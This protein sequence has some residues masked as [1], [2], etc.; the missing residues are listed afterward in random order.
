MSLLAKAVAIASTLLALVQGSKISLASRQTLNTTCAD[1]HYFEARGTTLPYPGSLIT[2]IDPLMKAFPNSNYE[3]IVYPATDESGSD[4]YFVGVR[5]GAK[6]IISY[7]EACPE[8]KIV[9]M[10]YSQG[11][12]VLGDILAGGGDGNVLGNY[13]KPLVDART[14]GD[15][16]AAILLYGNPRHMPNQTYNVGNASTFGAT[17]KYPRTAGQLASFN[18]YADRVHDYCNYQDGVCDASGSNLT[19]HM[20]YPSDYDT[21][22]IAWLNSKLNAN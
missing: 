12:M 7:A 19:A 13:T 10:G 18:V 15:H 21:Q 4:S 22:A 20:A 11:A 17:G 9:L 14:V 1:V 6:Q 8:S 16:I 5:D 3:D 2:V